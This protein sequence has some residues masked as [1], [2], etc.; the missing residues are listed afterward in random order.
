M[1][2]NKFKM[3]S[4]KLFSLLTIK[5]FQTNYRKWIYNKSIMCLDRVKHAIDIFVFLF[6]LVFQYFQIGFE[7]LLTKSCMKFHLLIGVKCQETLLF[8]GIKEP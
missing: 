5:R 6:L 2:K 1:L 7:C 3:Y 4:L 8:K